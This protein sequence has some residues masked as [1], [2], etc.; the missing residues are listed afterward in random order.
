MVMCDEDNLKACVLGWRVR[1]WLDDKW[2]LQVRQVLPFPTASPSFNSFA[3]FLWPLKQ[4]V[5]QLSHHPV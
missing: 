2:D 5:L 4:E 3:D 1:L